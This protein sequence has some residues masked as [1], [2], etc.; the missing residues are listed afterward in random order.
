MI[1]YLNAVLMGIVEGATEFIPVSS[2]GHL[3]L[4]DSVIKI[5][6]SISGMFEIVIQLGAILA[7]VVH[8][9]QRFIP[10]PFKS[11]SEKTETLNLY[12]KLLTALLPA[13]VFGSIF[14]SL[15]QKHLFKPVPVAV[16]LLLGGVA[17][18]YFGKERES[19]RFA[20]VSDLT[21]KAALLIG[22]FQCLAM[23]PGTS[24][25]AATI[26]GA[27][28]LGTSRKAAAEFSF[29][30]A[31]PTMAAATAYSL[32]SLSSTPSPSDWLL[33]GI[34]FVTSF[35]VA[36]AVIV[37]FMRYISAHDFKPF[38]YYRIILACAI[39]LYAIL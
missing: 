8:F 10:L 20:E 2:T 3:I 39:L 24:R 5:P 29:L 28:W 27:M 6:D 15:I 4:L 33:V 32:M 26:I 31:V 34:G 13:I 1:E 9:R 14:G 16:A 22:L 30:L 25:S 18:I 35:V 21:F 11:E 23:F 38:G 12:L 36:L 7:V 19:A 37:A 17:L